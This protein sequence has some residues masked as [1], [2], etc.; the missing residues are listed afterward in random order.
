MVQRPTMRDVAEAA[1]V[2]IKTVSRVVNGEALVRPELQERVRAQVVRLG[3]RLDARAGSFRS[4]RTGTIGV[5]LVD[6][7]NPF[8]A[9]VNRGVED[10]AHEHNHLVLSGSGDADP[11]REVALTRA[12]M[13]Q[14]VDGLVIAPTAEPDEVLRQEAV[15]GMPV[16]F[17]DHL[18]EGELFGDAVLTDHRH[19]AWLATS[20][21]VEFGHRRIAFLG[22][23]GRL[24]STRERLAGHAQALADAGID[25]DDSIVVTGVQNIAMA[26]Q[27]TR[28]LLASDDPPS[29]LFTAMNVA[30]IGAVQ[31]LHS[32]GRQSDV[33]LVAFDDVDFSSVVQPALTVVPQDARALGQRAAQRLFSRLDGRAGP[34]E[35]ELV[36]PEL[37][38]RG[39]GEIAPRR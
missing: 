9:A 25:V 38:A 21:L 6:G 10:V 27:R 36:R 11:E 4:Q 26:Q 18:P 24:H 22:D 29:A 14:R 16:V 7:A 5:V 17:V 3:Y 20:H 12:L 35:V 37:V 31:A 32:L 13:S 30:T 1:G 19:G 34:P 39:S 28:D 23:A 2:S 33:A 15:R 8:F